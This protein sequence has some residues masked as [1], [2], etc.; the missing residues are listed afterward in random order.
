MALNVYEKPSDNHSTPCTP[1]NIG[2]IER[3]NARI[4][5]TLKSCGA[6]ES[7]IVAIG[8]AQSR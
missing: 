5:N 4:I 7:R 1:E 6:W 2:K 3:G 8:H